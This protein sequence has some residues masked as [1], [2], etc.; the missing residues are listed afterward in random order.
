MQAKLQRIIANLSAVGPGTGDRFGLMPDFV[1]LDQQV[2]K[3]RRNIARKKTDLF[4]NS[5]REKSI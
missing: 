5:G 2:K 4:L 1:K 3:T